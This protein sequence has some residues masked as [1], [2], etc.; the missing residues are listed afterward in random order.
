MLNK[1]IIRIC[2]Q[3]L[4]YLN[5]SKNTTKIYLHYIIKFLIDGAS[6][7]KQLIDKCNEIIIT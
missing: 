2:E 1:K 4:I 7:Y 5:Y 6:I 3:K